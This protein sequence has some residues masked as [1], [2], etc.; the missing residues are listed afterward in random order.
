[1][2]RDVLAGFFG[3]SR[4]FLSPLTL[5]ASLFFSQKLIS[6]IRGSGITQKKLKEKK[7]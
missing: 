6:R 7:E 1:M 2:L 3:D 5:G 4:L